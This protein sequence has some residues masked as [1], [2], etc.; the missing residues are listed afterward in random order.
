[1]L[2]WLLAASCH[3]TSIKL[4]TIWA[5]LPLLL[6]WG[7]PENCF[8]GTY[9]L[10]VT[11]MRSMTPLPRYNQPKCNHIFAKH[12]LGVLSGLRSPLCTG[13]SSFVSCISGNQG[14]AIPLSTH[15]SHL[16]RYSLCIGSFH[17]WPLLHMGSIPLI[18]LFNRIDLL[19]KKKCF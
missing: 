3:P 18:P 9:H 13:K 10:A 6:L 7:S 16:N 2:V 15:S 17:W 5:A 1:M 12:F 14:S 19:I 8:A 4:L 11:T